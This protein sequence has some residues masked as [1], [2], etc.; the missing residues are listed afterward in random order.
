MQPMMRC[1]EVPL[2]LKYSEGAFLESQ[3]WGSSARHRQGASPR[4]SHC[5]TSECTWEPPPCLRCSHFYLSGAWRLSVSRAA[6]RRAWSNAAR[7]P[8]STPRHQPPD[9][10]HLPDDFVCG[11][12][13]RWTLCARRVMAVKRLIFVWNNTRLRQRLRQPS[14]LLPR[15]P[16]SLRQPQR[17]RWRVALACGRKGEGGDQVL[18]EAS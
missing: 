18:S 10:A 4:V 7:P 17:R 1:A 14:V 8:V 16:G 11:V 3:W 12:N 9:D 6:S 15:P 13:A 5:H 2:K